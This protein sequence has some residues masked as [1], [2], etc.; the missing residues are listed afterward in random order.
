MSWFLGERYHTGIKPLVSK[1][2]PN[3]SIWSVMVKYGREGCIELSSH[4]AQS[5][6]PSD[7]IL[8]EGLVSVAKDLVTR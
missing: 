4:C 2:G 5:L 3:Q 8:A 1:T 6:I 7:T